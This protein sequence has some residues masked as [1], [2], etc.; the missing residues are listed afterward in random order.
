[1]KRAVALVGIWIVLAV[2]AGCSG[3]R[4]HEKELPDPSSYEAHFP[5]IDGDG[6]ERVTWD[7][8]HNYFP[9]ATEEV[10]EAVDLDRN[11]ALDHDEWHEFK[12]AHGLKSHH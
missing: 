6:D 2:F 4:F 12:E 10:F 5:D 7:E 11:K 8:F 1:M 3:A 9:Q